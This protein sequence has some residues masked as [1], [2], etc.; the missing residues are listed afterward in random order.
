MREKF[1]GV[2]EIQRGQNY[3][4]PNN[5]SDPFESCDP[6]ESPAVRHPG[7]SA[8]GHRTA[9]ARAVRLM[10]SAAAGAFELDREDPRLRDAYGRNPFGQG[11]LLARRLVECGV[12]F[13]EVT[14]TEAP[15]QRNVFGWDTHVQNF[16]AVKALSGVLDAGWS[17]LLDDLRARGRLDS[18]LIVWMGEFGRTPKINPNAGRDHFPNAWTTV[19][20]GGGVRGGQ[21]YG[22]TTADATAVA[23][24][25][26]TVPDLLSTVCHA[27]GIDPS[28]QNIS[29]VGRP[30]RIVD[31]KSRPIREVLA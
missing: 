1:K 24:N 19:L 2:R 12:P 15:G 29:D 4:N 14:L 27:L 25:P 21:A 13:V 11:C 30:I 8:S 23:D 10:R 5:K 31:P 20:A 3:L 6:F 22:R 28:T 9:H 16:G 26:V 17:T 18:T 7:A